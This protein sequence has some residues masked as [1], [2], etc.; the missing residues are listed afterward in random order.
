MRTLERK[1]SFSSNKFSPRY[2]LSCVHDNR[3]AV[4]TPDAYFHPNCINCSEIIFMRNPV[5]YFL[6]IT[7]LAVS[8]S[9]AQDLAQAQRMLESGDFQKAKAA[10]TSILQA[11]P[12]HKQALHLRGQ[13]RAALGDFYG[14]ISDFTHALEVDSTQA[15]VYNDRGLAKVNLGDDEGGIE[16]FDKAIKFN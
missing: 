10:L 9:S 5:I 13:A 6:F 14:A 1:K 2:T 16:D 12:K 4:A 11:Q 15:E 7:F 8:T 3:I